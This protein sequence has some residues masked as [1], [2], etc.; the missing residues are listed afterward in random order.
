MSSDPSNMLTS[1]REARS[2]QELHLNAKPGIIWTASVLKAVIR[3]I[4]WRMVGENNT[5]KILDIGRLMMGKAPYW[6]RVVSKS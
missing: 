5:R 4:L 3:Q 6:T 2:A 1:L